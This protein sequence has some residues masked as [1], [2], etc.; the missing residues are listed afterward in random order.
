MN[1]YTEDGQQSLAE[2]MRIADV[3]FHP[4][5]LPIHLA[6]SLLE[7]VPLDP[8]E[9]GKVPW[10]SRFSDIIKKADGDVEEFRKSI[11]TAISRLPSQHPPA[12]SISVS[13]PLSQ[14]LRQASALVEFRGDA[15]VGV[16]HLIWAATQDPEISAL[17][18]QANTKKIGEEL[19]DFEPQSVENKDSTETYPTEP[20]YTINL[21][22]MAKKGEMDP[23]IGRDEEIRRLIAILLHRTR[24]NAILVGD[25]GV[26]KTSIVKGLAQRIVAGD[27]PDVLADWR[28]LSLGSDLLSPEVVS[29]DK[30]EERVT[31]ILKELEDSKVVTCLF[32]DDLHLLWGTEERGGPPNI[33][34]V[35]KSLFAKGKLHHCIATATPAEFQTLRGRSK[36][37]QEQFVQISVQE[38]T[39]RETVSILRGLKTNWESH[40]GIQISEDAVREAVTLAGPNLPQSAI[41]LIDETLAF[42]Q[43]TTQSGPETLGAMK[44]KEKQLRDEIQNLE[45]DK[46]ES[47][48]RYLAEAKQDQMKLEEKLKPLQQQYEN[49][50]T[51]T[52]DIKETMSKIGVAKS[53]LVKAE[54]E[55]DYRKA[56][57]LQ[58]YALP[59]LEMTLKQLK[60][61]KESA[62]AA[63]YDQI[64]DEDS[65]AFFTHTISSVQVKKMA[66]RLAAEGRIAPRSDPN[67]KAT[68]PIDHG[69]SL[70]SDLRE[71]AAELRHAA[72]PTPTSL[73]VALDQKNEL[74]S[75]DR[76]AAGELPTHQKPSELSNAS[77]QEPDGTTAHG[78]QEL[79]DTSKAELE[80]SRPGP[81]YE[82]AN[83]PSLGKIE[84]EDS[85]RYEAPAADVH[86]RPELEGSWVPDMPE[87][88]DGETSK[89]EGEREA[90]KEKE[91]GRWK[92][93]LKGLMSRG[94]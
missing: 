5:L 57:D 11:K 47:S 9:G 92:G 1:K 4:A 94:K 45:Q 35:L 10:S 55:R 21:T 17:L 37:L 48:I 52:K 65:R 19:F 6:Q 53:R 49:V 66:D 32:I 87:L 69:D 27:V 91:R 58:Y 75:S 12:E 22:S 34:D 31:R 68:I 86:R 15:L 60:I 77:R 30:L 42:V 50:Q 24:N 25:R 51:L 88:G 81:R 38:P 26:G 46:S 90:K 13:S 76:M 59:D 85:K 29:K 89:G 28:I 83:N 54:K 71:I 2:A 36:V 62:S 41:D 20:E 44:R 93:K 79:S 16:D 73:S 84:L 64:I 74:P 63:L 72:T 56:A 70:T 40:Y 67:S 78:P 14:I 8:S 7:P 61:D 18:Y 43:L 33:S 3:N 23:V 82:L 80:A 39:P